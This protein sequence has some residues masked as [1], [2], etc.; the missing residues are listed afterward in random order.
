MKVCYVLEKD[1]IHFTLRYGPYL[2]FSSCEHVVT[3]KIP[4]GMVD[5]HRVKFKNL[6]FITDG[7]ANTWYPN[8]VKCSECTYVNGVIQGTSRMWWKSGQLQ[9][10]CYKVDG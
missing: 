5:K 2:S 8:G 1:E 4:D 10:E 6:K 9:S 7:L 3:E